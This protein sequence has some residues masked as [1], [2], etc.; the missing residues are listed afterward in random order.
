MS[1][2]VGE[3]HSPYSPPTLKPSTYD[4]PEALAPAAYN[5]RPSPPTARPPRLGPASSYAR[6]R[7]PLPLAPDP[8][9]DRPERP[10]TAPP[11][12]KTLIFP[13]G[14]DKRLRLAVAL[15]QD[16]EEQH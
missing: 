14:L 8:S 3:V 4:P 9:N 7:R 12:P 10:Q 11:H 15:S 6:P 1:L 13:L 2:R 16:G 5:T